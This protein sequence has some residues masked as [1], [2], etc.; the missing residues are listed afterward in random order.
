MKNITLELS[1]EET[2]LVLGALGELP[3]SRVF[4]LIGKVQEQANKQLGSDVS[5]AQPEP[6]VAAVAMEK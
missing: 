3:F 1:V 6:P 5:T 2:N 4:N